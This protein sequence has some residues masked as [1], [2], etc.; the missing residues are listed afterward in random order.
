MVG[1]ALSR[2]TERN[3]RVFR[4]CQK[5]ITP[6]IIFSDTKNTRGY[7]SDYS[8]NIIC[9]QQK[10]GKAGGTARANKLT[11]ERRCEIAQRAADIKYY[12]KPLP[13]ATHSGI[14]S[15]GDNNIDCAVLEDGTRIITQSA[16]KRAMGSKSNRT[17]PLKDMN[18]KTIPRLP[19]FV[20]YESLK[21][22]ITNS[23][24]PSLR[25][26]IYRSK[27]GHLTHGFKAE[28]LP[29]I[30]D[31]YLKARDADSLAP[32][33]FH[34][35]K[36]CDILIRALA[37]VGITALVDEATSFP[38]ELAE[39][40]LLFDKFVS[41]E[42]QP[43]IKRFP[44]DFFKNIRKLYGIPKE[45][46]TPSFVGHFINKYIYNTLAPGLKDELKRMNPSNENGARHHRHHQHLTSDVGCSALDKQIIRINTLMSLSDTK[47]EFDTMFKKLN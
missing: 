2:R 30:C 13:K 17:V 46:K 28:A 25:P 45:S 39:L 44:D 11:S 20:A 16:M 4:P 1:F 38:R 47:D 7:M 9:Y 32:N 33:Q 31:I 42:L 12:G 36:N 22:F 15:I 14:L 40:R 5:S 19:V 26:V 34:I 3:D 29:I 10:L 23:I 43:W 24:I 37:K 35:A 18:N 6:G 41:E 21:P 27:N 8:K